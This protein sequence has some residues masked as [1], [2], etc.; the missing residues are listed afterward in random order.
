[1]TLAQE[2]E[3]VRRAR[4][5]AHLAMVRHLTHVP[6][7]PEDQVLAALV[8]GGAEKV[9][10][11]CRPSGRC[12]GVAVQ[13]RGAAL[14]EAISRQLGALLDDRAASQF[15]ALAHFNGHVDLEF[16][17]LLGEPSWV[18]AGIRREDGEALDVVLA[19]EGVPDAERARV[20]AGRPRGVA[21]VA[22]VERG[23]GLLVS[24]L[25]DAVP[26]G[27]EG[28]VEGPAVVEHVAG[29]PDVAWVRQPG[30]S[31]TELVDLGLR[32]DPG[33]EMAR[34]LGALHGALETERPRW[35]ARAAHTDDVV[36]L[37]DVPRI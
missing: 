22:S 8:R 2:S 33:P 12:L 17:L 18:R 5:L 6:E 25:H 4:V 3:V 37:Y 35:M 10:L 32:Y 31:G 26:S 9:G 29:W 28:L 34:R 11:M 1:M 20:L 7:G 19:G 27:L 14:T 30:V 23:Y 16:E 21:L 15:R 36:L 13:G 24:G